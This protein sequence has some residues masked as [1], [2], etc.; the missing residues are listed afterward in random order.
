M[1]VTYLSTHALLVCN[2]ARQKEIISRYNEVV[3]SLHTEAKHQYQLETT[4]PEEYCKLSALFCESVS[5]KS[6]FVTS[7]NRILIKVTSSQ[8]SHMF[9]NYGEHAGYA[10]S[11]VWH[12]KLLP[13]SVTIVVYK[14]TVRTKRT[15][16]PRHRENREFGSYFFQTGKTQG[17][18]FWHREKF[19]NT[20][21]IFELWLLI[22]KVCLF[23]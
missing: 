23:F 16:W 11:H 7:L 1:I 8:L 5:S 19:V 22:W 3:G 4:L 6:N 9:W 13:T 15:G 12:T 14:L 20:G 2:E 10:R 18:L 17:I 21:K